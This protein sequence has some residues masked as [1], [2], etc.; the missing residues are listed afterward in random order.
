MELSVPTGAVQQTLNGV[1]YS[2]NTYL[3]SCTI[4]TG[5][6]TCVASGSGIG[7]LR[8]VV[9]VTWSGR[10]CS[11]G[12]CTYLSATLVN[13]DP[14]PVFNTNTAVPPASPTITDPGNQVSTVGG[15][16][17][18]Q[19]SVDSGTGVPP[20]T[21]AITT[22]ALPTGLTL[23][24][25]GLVTGTPTA[26]QAAASLTVSVSDAFGRTGAASFTWKVVAPPTIT[27]PTAQTSTQGTAVSLT[28]SY[29]CL[30]IPCTFALAGAPAGLSIN[31]STG[32]V[33]GTPT[34]AGTS[35]TVTVTVTDAASVSA[36]TAA[37]TWRIVSLPTIGNPGTLGTT[38]T[39][40]ESVPIAYTCSAP[41]CTITL[42]GT[43]P[44]LGLSTTATS[45]TANNT[46]TSLTVRAASGTVYVA[47]TT[48]SSAVPSGTS[49]A[50]SP[51]LRI[52]DANSSAAT[53]TTGTWTAYTVPTVG[54]LGTRTIPV[55]TSPNVA[56]PYTCPNAPCTLTLAQSPAGLG[57][58][59]TS[60]ATAAN[61]TST[62]TLTATSGTVYVN[63]TVDPS[64]APT[65]GTRG[66]TP[67]LNITDSD[68]ASASAT[69]S[70]TITRSPSLTN[71]GSQVV[72]LYNGFSLTPD[73]TCP[74]TGCTFALSSNATFLGPSINAS[75]GRITWT[76]LFTGT[77]TFTV[78]VTDSLG[79]T[80]TVSFTVRVVSSVSVAVP[81]QVTT[82]PAS[83]TSTVTL[84]AAS[85]VTPAA[86]GYTYA[87]RNAP[88]WL[89]ID[90]AT[91]L[92]TA[93]TTSSSAGG[94]SITL[95]VT[96]TASSATTAS[97]TF[98]W[99]LR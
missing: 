85:Y 21:W 69:G 46:T 61:S 87:L 44:G 2:V 66:Y 62:L 47:G 38:V 42:S 96:S 10:G 24:A 27:T 82:R 26:T 13:A 58:S 74:N 19:L 48:Q 39:S 20:L 75:S 67:T 37:F 35:S 53:S 83:G 40:T 68:A 94:A 49:R 63:G 50:W 72:Q 98:S 59:T 6:S 60:G 16:V 11:S 71:P 4:A 93:T 52:V 15:A 91:G 23:S 70:W 5:A 84:D 99:T 41:A 73:S 92:M 56:V 57:L 32:V 86:D 89:T 43:V 78:R 80:D 30:N 64:A 22:G 9:A 54:A 3:G 7:Y 55:R 33:S 36:A 65:G 79:L 31:A 1:T 8:A 29:T 25:S 90:S 81:N 77:Y 51:S 12:S 88:S 17:S 45:S 14:D 95:T 28:V 76:P 97:D 34:T 18:L